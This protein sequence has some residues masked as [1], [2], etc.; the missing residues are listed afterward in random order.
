MKET[1]LLSIILSIL[2]LIFVLLR[3]YA[4]KYAFA[5]G[6]WGCKNGI[7]KKYSDYFNNYSIDKLNIRG[8]D[9]DLLIK[10]YYENINNIELYIPKLINNHFYEKQITYIENVG[11]HIGS[12]NYYTPKLV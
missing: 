5:G 8:M 11:S 9:Q 12:F 6:G 10:I 2:N 7:L 4:V 1:F 3:Q